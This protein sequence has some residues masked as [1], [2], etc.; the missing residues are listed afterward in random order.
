MAV[1]RF[2]FSPRLSDEYVRMSNLVLST[3]YGLLIHRFLIRPCR[4]ERFMY[5]VDDRLHLDL[6]RVAVVT[7][8]DTP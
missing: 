1:L 6:F 5:H 8:L 3:R 7:V 2:I 4:L